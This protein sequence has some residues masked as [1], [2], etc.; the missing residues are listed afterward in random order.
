MHSGEHVF[1]LNKVSRCLKALLV[2]GMCGVFST[3][4]IHTG[5]KS[6][7]AFSH[8][9]TLLPAPG[10]GFASAGEGSSPQFGYLCALQG[11]ALPW[12][13]ISKP[14]GAG[15]PLKWEQGWEETGGKKQLGFVQQSDAVTERSLWGR[16]PTSGAGS[17]EELRQAARTSSRTSTTL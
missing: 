8:N 7:A 3:C 16:F 17:V 1:N 5:F 6:C 10:T 2:W 11:K 9:V 14:R 4:L 12:L 15:S 13:P